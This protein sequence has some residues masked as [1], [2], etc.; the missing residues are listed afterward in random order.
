RSFVLLRSLSLISALFTY[1]TLFRSC[2]GLLK[3]DQTGEEKG[4][5]T[6]GNQSDFTEGLDKRC[7]LGSDDH[8]TSQGYISTGTGCHSIDRGQ[9]RKSTRLNSSHV[10]I[11]YA[12]FCLQT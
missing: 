11:S 6:V 7:F 10:S 9:D 1:T 5:P 8:I 12:V 2:T 4:A 3:T